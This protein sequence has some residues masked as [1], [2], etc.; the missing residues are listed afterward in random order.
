MSNVGKVIRDGYCNGF[1]GRRYDL[2][3]SEIV[4]EGAEWL[5]IRTEK[6]E[7]LFASF[8]FE[9]DGVYIK[10]KDR[11]DLIDEWTGVVW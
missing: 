2:C 9:K 1:F 10:R 3:R 6:N 8:Q 7:I 11:Q 5:V 4:A